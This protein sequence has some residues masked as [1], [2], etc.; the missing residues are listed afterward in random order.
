MPLGRILVKG[1]P[2]GTGFALAMRSG[3]PSQVVLTARH[4][5]KV[6]GVK[7]PTLHASSDIVFATE[8]GQEIQVE[9]VEGNEI[10]DVA[11]LRLKEAVSEGLRVH[12]GARQETK[13]QTEA[14]PHASLPILTGTVT[15]PR[16]RV[17]NAD[18]Y[19]TVAMQLRVEEAL[20]D[21]AGYSGSP[22]TLL[23]QADAVIG[24]V[25]EQVPSQLEGQLGEAK[26]AT[27]VMYATPIRDVLKEFGL[28]AATADPPVTVS[29][30]DLPA[31]A[32][33]REGKLNA[34]REDLREG[35]LDAAT[36]QVP[37][38]RMVALVGMGGA[39]KTVLA[40]QLARDPDLRSEFLDGVFWIGLARWDEQERESSL[41][42][43]Q[44]LLAEVLGEAGTDF[45]DSD[46]GRSHL[47]GLLADRACLIVLDGVRERKDLDAFNVLGP[48]GRLLFT[49]RER[50]LAESYAEKASVYELGL[51]LDDQARGLLADY[52]GLDVEAL[53]P[54]ADK[55]LGHCGGLPLA[56]AMAGA[57]VQGRLRDWPR[58][59]KKFEK[60]RIDQIASFLPGYDHP[61]LL[62]ALDVGVG[63]LDT[64]GQAK[65][66]SNARDR[67][68]DL[69]VFAGRRSFPETAMAALW[70]NAGVEDYEVR[71]YADLFVSRSLAT[72]DRAE[73]RLSLH[74]LQMDYL[75]NRAREQRQ[76]L[77]T[78]LVDGYAHH[79]PDGWASG[80]DDG[81]FFQN[82]PYH[83]AEAGRGDEL[84]ALLADIFWI[85]ATLAATGVA[86]L[87][88]A[89]NLVTEDPALRL[90]G[91]ALRLSARALTGHPDHLEGQ[92][93]GRLMD[94]DE[95]TVQR[96]L[97]SAVQ[98]RAGTTWLRPLTRGLEQPGGLLRRVLRLPN[99][100]QIVVARDQGIALS[101]DGRIAVCD[102]FVPI[103]WGSEV[104]PR[105]LVW[106]LHSME[107]PRELPPGPT[108]YPA[109]TADGRMAAVAARPWDL[110]LVDL[111]SG[112]VVDSTRTKVGLTCVAIAKGVADNSTRIVAGHQDGWVICWEP[113]CGDLHAHHVFRRG[114]DDVVS[115]E[116]SADGSTAVA[117]SRSGNLVCLPLPDLQPAQVVGYHYYAFD[118]GMSPNGRTV[119]TGGHDR[120]LVVWTL[121]CEEDEPRWHKQVLPA[122]NA[123]I[124]LVSAV[125]GNRAITSLEDGTIQVW[126]LTSGRVLA[127]AELDDTIWE[128]AVS[129]DGRTALARV[130]E[131]RVLVLD[132]AALES[133]PLVAQRGR[134]VA[135]VVTPDGRAAFSGSSRG[136]ISRFDVPTE[137]DQD[138]VRSRVAVTYTHEGGTYQ[139]S[140]LSFSGDWVGSV[141][142]L[143]VTAD[144]PREFDWPW[145][146]DVTKLAVTPDGQRL[147]WTSSD[148]RLTVWEGSV[149][150]PISASWKGGAL[151]TSVGIT[152]AGVIF[153]TTRF[154]RVF[155]GNPTLGEWGEWEDPHIPHDHVLCAAAADERSRVLGTRDGKV[156]IEARGSTP[157]TVAAHEARVE[158]VA[159]TPTGTDDVTVVSGARDGTIA[160]WQVGLL[161]PHLSRQ[162]RD[163]SAYEPVKFVSDHPS[164]I[165]LVLG[166]SD[167]VRVVAVS[168]DGEFA[169][170]GSDADDLTLWALPELTP[171]TSYHC[172]GEIEDIAVAAGARL[173]AVADAAGG[174]HLLSTLRAASET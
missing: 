5:V 65:G 3:E 58:V 129:R 39:G 105:I 114:D 132:L 127:S 36:E 124:S 118:F 28:T 85:R 31:H 121:E 16:L 94:H 99:N 143:D 26:R 92:L 34:I 109:V 56:I 89:Y 130:S 18:K 172:D 98:S 131:N 151:I 126:D 174:V 4:V 84:R 67:Y 66:L 40:A 69:A 17:E 113:D 160:V 1:T 135:V 11:I 70:W 112:V 79:C 141:A 103:D 122:Q 115:V 33:N 50:G 106:D 73:E 59:L 167:P 19:D 107:A 68:A 63:D 14:R 97:E 55:V 2:K 6:V 152:T 165:K 12:Y 166:H 76:A 153:A 45:A 150:P 149:R 139:D 137:P 110:S 57:M 120:K 117:I 100:R 154:G 51:L 104:G 164:P 156:L 108:A 41:V 145:T 38:G 42:A 133:E 91:E 64:A 23:S 81:Y 13:W 95:P 46:L 52:A 96:L 8:A 90:V 136:V 171:L 22:V 158:T 161:V 119:V 21:F 62:V 155:Y 88:F 163:F 27:N 144:P 128:L 60:A 82:L 72:W 157:I 20:E 93:L 134:P 111:E 125:D 74:D 169:V 71:D 142:A 32:L 173:V 25:V 86:S 37:S 138:R 49:T 53:P 123:R 170:S 168:A 146:T 47:R 75:A 44:A 116:I 29:P 54:E 10:L 24:L 35:L 7:P 30:P 78:R 148:H 9:S 15:K 48:R 61:N 101:A 159:V 162:R 77:H 80:P 83:L 102:T 87:V 140:R 147:A 43:R